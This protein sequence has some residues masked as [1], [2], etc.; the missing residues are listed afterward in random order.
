[1]QKK[2]EWWLL[3]FG[4][5]WVG[6]KVIAKDYVSLSNFTINHGDGHMDL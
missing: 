2:V 6:K 4:E 5:K 1:M 3:K